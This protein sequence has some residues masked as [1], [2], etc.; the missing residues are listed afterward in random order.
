MLLHPCANVLTDGRQLKTFKHEVVGL[1]KP[2]KS[3]PEIKEGAVISHFH[4]NSIHNGARAKRRLEF[5]PVCAVFAPPIRAEAGRGESRAIPWSAPAPS[6]QRIRRGVRPGRPA[7]LRTG[8][9]HSNRSQRPRPRRSE[10]TNGMRS[11]PL[12]VLGGLTLSLPRFRLSSAQRSDPFR[13]N[14]M[15]WDVEPAPDLEVRPR[16]WTIAE[17]SVRGLGRGRGGK[18]ER[19]TRG[20]LHDRFA[21]DTPARASQYLDSFVSTTHWL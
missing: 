4:H 20:P 6:D 14:R 5:L 3:F 2:R 11:M 1:D 21:I 18:S 17:L 15:R 7:R 19:S 10:Q 13:V 12:S 9:R 16:G 8:R